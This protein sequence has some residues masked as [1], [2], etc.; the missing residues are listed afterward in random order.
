MSEILSVDIYCNANA[1]IGYGHIRRSS[2]LAAFLQKENVDV[3]LLG[4]S[5]EAKAFLPAINES[6]KPATVAVFDVAEG[7]DEMIRKAKNQ[8]QLTVTLDWFGNELPDINIVVF[9]HAEVKAIRNTYTGF[10]YIILREEILQTKTQKNTGQT[11]KVLVCL[12][13]SDLL[14]QGFD[15]AKFLHEKGF[16]VTLIQGPL[17][18]KIKSDADFSVLTNPIDFA[19]RLAASDWAVTNGGGC[20]FEAVF[21]EKAVF[22]LPQ[23]TWEKR[24]ADFVKEKGAL[25]GIGIDQLR[26]FTE[27]EI[28]ST[29]TSAKGLID[30]KGA[31]RIAE[32]IKKE[33][34]GRR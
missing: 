15:T 18:K 4:I 27:N 28:L 14:N 21:F 31:E 5:E 20:L 3:R 25:L 29:A 13:G 6:E 26:S 12:G 7:I 34:A 22:V 23:T 9:P 8:Q 17:A 32:I 1:Q 30:G 10:E 33:Y 19:D 24:I 16:D 2:A 11:K